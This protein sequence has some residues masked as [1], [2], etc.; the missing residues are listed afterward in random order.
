MLRSA[1]SQSV[2]SQEEAAVGEEAAS[3]F[4]KLVAQPEV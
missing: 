4:W 2:G 3:Y 1:V